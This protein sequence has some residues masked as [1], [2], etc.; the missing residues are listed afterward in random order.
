MSKGTASFGK[1]IKRH[2]HIKCKRCG[3][4]SFHVRKKVCAYCG[5]GK[6]KKRND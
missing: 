4:Y 2:T 6:S 5:Y 1:K 3:R